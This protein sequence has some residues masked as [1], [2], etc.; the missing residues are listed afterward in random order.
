MM[1]VAARHRALELLASC[2]DGCPETW[3]R[4]YHHQNSE[5]TMMLENFIGSI[6]SEW[7]PETGFFWKIRQGEFRKDEFDRALA[8]F[9]AVPS[10][11]EE[12][13][14]ARLV[15]VLWYVPIF[16]QWQIHRVRERGGD[17]PAYEI[18]M[19][20]LG[21]EVERILGVP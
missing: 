17:L 18:A 20:Q 4:N 19:A 10:M 6:E 14:P 2:R 5:S 11:S 9:A 8:K 7:E 21:N 3:K 12:P 13:L 15:S 1:P 16:M